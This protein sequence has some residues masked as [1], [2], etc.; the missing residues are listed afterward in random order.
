MRSNSAWTSTGSRRS[1]RAPT[2]PRCP[3][4]PASSWA[5]ST[6]AAA[7]SR[8]WTAGCASTCRPRP[9]PPRP[10]IIILDLAGQPTGLM[11]D[12]VSEV[13]KLD[14]FTLRETPPLVAGVRSDYL[15]GMVTAAN[16]LITLINLEKILDST[17]FS[18]RAK[19]TEKGGGSGIFTSR[20]HPGRGG[21]GRG[22]T[23][24]RHLHPGQGVLRDQPQ[25]GRGDHRAARGHQGAGRPALRHGGHLPAG[26][27]AAAA[28]LHPDAARRAGGAGGAGRHGDPAQ[29]RP[30][31]AGHRGGRHPGD[32]PDQGRGHPAAAPDPQRAG[33]GRPGGDRAPLRPHGEPAQGPGHHQRRGPG[34]DRRHELQPHARTR[35]GGAGRPT[36]C[37]WWCSAWAARPIPC[38]CTKCGK[39]SWSATSPPSPGRP[40]SSRGCST[41]AA[42]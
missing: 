42:R 37:R 30:G 13:V 35:R 18:E 16:R 3:A 21:A 19:L 40:R 10:A 29:L 28:R 7:S 31:Q 6:C 33:S 12:S 2:S 15:A 20:R 39:S 34:Q 9:P 23:A 11:V 8:C 5:S 32:H 25:D 41:C 22:G 1:P 27:G 38:A 14:D 4:R 17:E 24:L 26:P 36:N